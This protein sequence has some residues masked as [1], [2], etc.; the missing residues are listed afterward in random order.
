MYEMCILIEITL[1]YIFVKLL[2]A[3]VRSV[4]NTEF[5]FFLK[6]S[7]RNIYL[8]VQNGLPQKLLNGKIPRCELC[9]WFATFKIKLIQTM[10]S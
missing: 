6:I 9:T 10:T 2:N 1:A 7:E 5:K 8:K 3:S 4:Q